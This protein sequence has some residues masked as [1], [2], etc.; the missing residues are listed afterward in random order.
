VAG[1]FH[2]I[3]GPDDLKQAEVLANEVPRSLIAG[4]WV[5]ARGKKQ[6]LVFESVRRP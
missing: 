5:C 6:F 4:G 1:I 3:H 2:G